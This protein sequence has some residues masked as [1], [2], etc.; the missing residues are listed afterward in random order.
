VR[1]KGGLMSLIKGLL[2]SPKKC[3]IEKSAPFTRP[4]K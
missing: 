2:H 1:V 4:Q 3:S